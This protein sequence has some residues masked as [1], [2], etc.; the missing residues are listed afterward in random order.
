M[1]YSFF[2][3]SLVMGS[4]CDEKF[5]IQNIYFENIYLAL[6]YQKNTYLLC[7]TKSLHCISL[8]LLVI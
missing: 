8:G 3:V 6:A 4:D 7:V 5:Y 1:L 2:I